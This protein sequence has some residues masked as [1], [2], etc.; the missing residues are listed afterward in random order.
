MLALLVSSAAN[1]KGP[2]SEEN[3]LEELDFVNLSKT[4]L[5]WAQRE[6]MSVDSFKE[7]VVSAVAEH[8]GDAGLPPERPLGTSNAPQ[9]QGLATRAGMQQRQEDRRQCQG[10]SWSPGD[11]YFVP[12]QF[13]LSLSLCVC[14]HG[15]NLLQSQ[16]ALLIAQPG[17]ER[18]P[19]A[20]K[21]SNLEIE[22]KQRL[23][24]RFQSQWC[25][26][27]HQPTS[28]NGQN[29]AKR[30][31]L[32]SDSSTAIKAQPHNQRASLFFTIP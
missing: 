2:N 21:W 15:W 18:V 1:R 9:L 14:G 28:S 4:I 20:Q 12:P 6:Q 19:E 23:L 22:S 5:W 24:L 30:F 25:L 3:A 13:S 17:W 26:T 16:Q 32:E 27:P 29:I 8:R 10:R 31:C 7:A 11:C